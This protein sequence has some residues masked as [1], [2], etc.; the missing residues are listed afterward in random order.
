MLAPPGT[1]PSRCTTLV[2][3]TPQE[4]DIHPAR[5]RYG[6]VPTFQPQGVLPLPVPVGTQ[7]EK[8]CEPDVSLEAIVGGER[9][10]MPPQPATCSDCRLLTPATPLRSAAKGSNIDS[11]G[12]C[13]LPFVLKDL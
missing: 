13:K 11:F 5:L 12:R 2:E 6:K 8:A 4:H 7:A 10:A 1:G 3:S 9:I